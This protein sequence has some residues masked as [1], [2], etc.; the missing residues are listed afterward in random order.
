MNTLMIG[1]LGT[2]SPLRFTHSRYILNSIKTTSSYYS[3]TSSK[4]RNAQSYPVFNNRDGPPNKSVVRMSTS[5]DEYRRKAQSILPENADSETTTAIAF[6]L[7][8]SE[9]EKEKKLEFQEMEL[10]NEKKLEVQEMELKNEKKMEVLK[11]ELKNEKKLEVL[12]MELEMKVQKLESDNK[13]SQSTA[14]HSK[15]LS[16]VVQR[17][18]V[19]ISVRIVNLF[20]LILFSRHLPHPFFRFIFF[21]LCCH[22]DKLSRAFCEMS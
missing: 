21:V 11:M 20:V 9:L 3:G 22:T 10:K 8:Q 12:K 14:F 19:C 17:L 18:V 15:Q 5:L 13:Q 7:M 1:L 4:S 2:C 16:A 6:H